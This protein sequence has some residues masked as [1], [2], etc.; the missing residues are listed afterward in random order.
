MKRHGARKLPTDTI[1]ETLRD[2]RVWCKLGVV[3][4]VDGEST[5]YSID[6]GDIVVDVVL[7]PEGTPMLCRLGTGSFAGAW[8]IPAVGTEVL[9]AVPEGDLAADPVIVAVLA[10]GSTADGLSETQAV[11]AVPSGGKVLIHDGSAGSA[12]AL[13]YKSDADSL[14]STL[15][16]FKA[17]FDAHVHPV[18]TTGTATAQTGTAAVTAT[19]APSATAPVGT[20]TLKSK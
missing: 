13:A 1:K 20:Q 10:S 18:A 4:L 16:A 2:T 14:K 3:S 6:D 19:P 7:M 5:H 17:V 11:I 15:D 8:I 12:K 9:V